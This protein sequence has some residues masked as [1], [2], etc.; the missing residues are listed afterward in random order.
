M[1]AAAL[2]LIP[3][4]CRY[5]SQNFHDDPPVKKFQP[6]PSFMGILCLI[7]IALFRKRAQHVCE[8]ARRKGCNLLG[9]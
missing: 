9:E 1:P 4:F 8:D 3:R 7:H 5:F 2:N 6:T